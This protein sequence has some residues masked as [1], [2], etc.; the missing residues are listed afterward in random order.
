MTLVGLPPEMVAGA[1]TPRRALTDVLPDGHRHTLEGQDP[2]STRRSWH[3]SSQTSSPAE[4]AA[5]AVPPQPG[6]VTSGS[7]RATST[8]TKPRAARNA[9]ATSTPTCAR[10]ALAAPVASSSAPIAVLDTAT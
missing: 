4:R 2:T 6:V 5:H 10:A 8:P 1:R 7:E 3:R 9:S